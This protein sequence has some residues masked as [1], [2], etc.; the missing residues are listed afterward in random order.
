MLRSSAL[1]G[2]VG[3]GLIAWG[4]LELRS[5]RLDDLGDGRVLGVGQPIVQSKQGECVARLQKCLDFTSYDRRFHD[6][7]PF[8]QWKDL[9]KAQGNDKRAPVSIFQYRDLCIPRSRH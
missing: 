7:I 3:A 5:Q 1:N 8:R 6:S 9:S 4:R 2:Q